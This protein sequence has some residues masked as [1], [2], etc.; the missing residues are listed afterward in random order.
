MM[1]ENMKEM[2][3]V[4]YLQSFPRDSFHFQIRHIIHGAGSW[5]SFFNGCFWSHQSLC[6]FCGKLFDLD[7]HS[8]KVGQ[9]VVCPTFV[10]TVI[11]SQML[12]TEYIFYI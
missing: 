8:H 7:D 3:I 4:Q 9:F 2:L 12:S 10:G 6:I 1:P 11:K 5:L